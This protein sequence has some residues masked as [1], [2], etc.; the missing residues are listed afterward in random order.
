[1]NKLFKKIF[2]KETLLEKCLRSDL[3][4]KS[5]LKICNK[6]DLGYNYNFNEKDND[7]NTPLLMACVNGYNHIIEKIISKQVDLIFVTNLKYIDSI[8]ILIMTYNVFI[9]NIILA[10]M[11]DLLIILADKGQYDCLFNLLNMNEILFDI[12][13]V[14]TKNQT[15]LLVL[16][17][18]NTKDDNSVYNTKYNIELVI[19]KIIDLD[20]DL[21]YIVDDLCNTVLSFALKNNMEY[22]ANKIID[23]NN[24]YLI[25]HY[26]FFKN[27][28]LGTACEKSM[29]DTALKLVR[30]YNSLLNPLEKNRLG[31][32][33]F[34]LACNNGLVEVAKMII[35]K[36]PHLDFRQSIKDIENSYRKNELVEYIISTSNNPH[37]Y[38]TNNILPITPTILPTISPT[39]LNVVHV[40]TEIPQNENLSNFDNLVHIS[41]EPLFDFDMYKNQIMQFI[42]KQFGSFTPVK[43]TTNTNI[44]AQLTIHKCMFCYSEANI[45][46]I[47]L[48]P[49]GHIIFSD[50]VCLQKMDSKCPYCRK[51]ITSKQNGYIME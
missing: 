40:S 6:I 30:N 23:L 43:T 33:P 24:Y 19:N 25:S 15:L 22:L 47:I 4:I 3:S 37:F 11:P 32:S 5:Q 31:K 12:E 7:G 10:K 27:N 44:K 50:L 17:S 18:E 45:K 16:C 13:Y 39:I 51:N 34:M 48:N 2:G 36:N 9:L 29:Y 1:M 21:N 28:P 42:T 8:N 38:Q 26:D 46:S 20:A 41:N 35:T 14:N 49:C